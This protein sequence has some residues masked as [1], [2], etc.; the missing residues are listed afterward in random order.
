MTYSL[1]TEAPYI[2][3]PVESGPRCLRLFSIAVISLPTLVAPSRWMRPAIPHM[4]SLP[5]LCPCSSRQAVEIGLEIP[6]GHG[7][8]ETLP[9]VA[10]IFVVEPVH[11]AGQR[12][13]DDIVL[14]ERLER[15]AE[16]HRQLLHLLA[17][18]HGL[19]DVALLGRPGI[20][21]AL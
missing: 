13:A 12:R 5:S 17:G 4:F 20:E 11:F 3:N 15:V 1:A 14:L 6:L 21:I 8:Q 16:R 2:A 7:V 19:I 9:L 18:L 10:L